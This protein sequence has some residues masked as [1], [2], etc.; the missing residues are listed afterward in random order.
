MKKFI[1]YIIIINIFN[2]IVC[3]NLENDLQN[4]IS[5]I[6]QDAY[7]GIK[8]FD[9]KNE[10]SLAQNN[11][12]HLFLPASNLKLFTAAAALFYLGPDFKFSTE[13]LTDG[14]VVEDT[15]EGNLYLKASGDP[16]LK[17][18][19][20]ENLV[21]ELSKNNIT[22]IKGNL[23][24][25]SSEFDDIEFG[26][27]WAWDDGPFFFN[28][29][30]NAF[31]VNHNCVKIKIGF[32]GESYINLT[33]ATNYVTIRSELTVDYS[34]EKPKI[35]INR[36]WR[37][38]ENIIAITGSVPPVE[39]EQKYYLT[40][41][42]PERFV[43]YL[44]LE[45]CN[46][47]KII[48]DGTI[49]KG[50]TPRS[51][52]ILAQHNS[53]Q[54]KILIRRLLKNSDNLY[55]ECFFKKIGCHLFGKPGTWQNGQLALYEFLEKI[56]NLNTK[57]LKIVDG[58]GLSRYN[59]VC[60]ENITSLLKW[61]YKSELSDHFIN[62][63]PCAGIDGTLKDRM[64]QGQAYQ[65]VRA[66]T[67]SLGGVTSLSGYVLNSNPLAFSILINNFVKPSQNY[68]ILEDEICNKLVQLSN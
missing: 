32:N 57:N 26:P 53:A 34:L 38:K 55:A 6:E 35:S 18:K 49:L 25:D 56:L 40:I 1:Y 24:I 43:A 37:Q 31:C 67:G 46:K 8:V 45:L 2:L 9:I 48:L 21:A 68:K 5:Q 36:S 51:C 13:I 58:S 11:A 14:D 60:P 61:I 12:H 50:H 62:A 7:F 28:S 33:P 20:V 4:I 52:K 65:I 63:L 47:Y 66:K 17:Y 19:D 54:L 27:G 39:F 64:Q 59:L 29:P 15:V 23:I 44:F 16:S 10:I 30:I 3:A 41:E 22:K 42:K